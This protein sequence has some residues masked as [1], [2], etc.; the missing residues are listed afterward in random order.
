MWIHEKTLLKSENLS[1]RLGENIFNDTNDK[2]LIP[3]I[4]N[5][6]WKSAR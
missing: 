4:N 6:L 5:G 2:R 3:I 1:Q